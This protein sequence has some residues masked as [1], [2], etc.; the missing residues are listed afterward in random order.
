M[1]HFGAGRSISARRRA[2]L[3]QPMARRTSAVGMQAA[4]GGLFFGWHVVGAAGVVAVFAWGISF[5]GPPIFLEAVHVERGWPISVTSAATTLHFLLGA[6]FVANLAN[7]HRR[8]GLVAVTRTG[9]VLTGLGLLGWGLAREPWQL[10]AMMPFSAAGWAMTSGAALNAMVSPWFAVRRPAALSMAFNGAS[11]GGVVFSPLWVALIASFGFARATGL[12][13]ATA[14]VALWLIAG[15]YFARRP[16]EMGLAADGGEAERSQSSNPWTTASVALV[17]GSGPWRDRRFLTLSVASMLALFAQVG[18]I[19]HLFSVLASSLGDTS[20]GL[21]TA[22]T[23][24]AAIS[25]RSLLG[26]LIRPA[27]NRRVVAAGNLAVQACGSLLLMTAHHSPPLLLAGCMLFGLGIGNVTSLPPLIAQ[28]EFTRDDVARIVALVTATSQ[29]GYAVA[30]LVFGGLRELGLAEGLGDAPVI[31]AAA[32]LIQ[33]A[34][35]STLVA[36]RHIARHTS[37]RAEV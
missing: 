2:M 37:A 34:A 27:T 3:H 31:F 22:L 10:F 8:F 4:R 28:N 20:A 1:L 14:S 35:A 12:V 13:A 29:A 24:A 21:I 5:Y 36:S 25:G 11:L 18:L 19:A 23:T 7:L 26:L 30:P 33:L 16:E 15:H 9:G 17:G 32:A 6:V